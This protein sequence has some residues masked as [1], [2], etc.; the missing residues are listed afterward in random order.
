MKVSGTTATAILNGATIKNNTLKIDNKV[1][2]PFNLGPVLKR[3]SVDDLNA[4]DK[5]KGLF[6]TFH[7]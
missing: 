7:Q 6:G 2:I 3:C 1:G 5:K 4:N